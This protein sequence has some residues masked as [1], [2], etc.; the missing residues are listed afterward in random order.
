MKY[1]ESQKDDATTFPQRL[2]KQ[3][4]NFIKEAYSNAEKRI[5]FLDY[6]GTL[7]GFHADPQKA[8]PDTALYRLLDRISAQE[9]TTLYLVSGRDK[10]TLARW[11]LSKKYNMIAE[12][13]AWI[14]SNGTHFRILGNLK[15]DWKVK[16]HPILVSFTN[17]TPGSFVEE[18][19]FSFAWHYRK[20]PAKIGNTRAGELYTL[21]NDSIDNEELSVLRGN[22][23]I[24]IKSSLMSKGNAIASI[25]AND[26][27]DFIFAIGDDVTDES[28]FQ[29]LPDNAVTVKVA[30]RQTAARY[31]VDSIKEVRAVLKHFQFS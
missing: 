18:K 4:L 10:T 31:Y 16:I 24:E 1:S 11:F 13:G 5:L 27:Y 15:N 3:R 2:T 26:T 14:S 7:T 9:K 21:L 25:L 17:K 19:D 8:V 12:H 22:K 6:D 30:N 23:V 20:T 28:M 29:E